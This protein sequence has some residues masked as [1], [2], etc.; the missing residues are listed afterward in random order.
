MSPGEK[1]WRVFYTL[2][3]AEK[4]CEERLVERYVETFLPKRSVWR[5]WTD[6]KKKVIE[7]LFPNYIFAQVNELERLRVLQTDGIVRCVSFNG[8]PAI[9]TEEEIEQIRIVQQEAIELALV[10]YRPE[11]GTTVVVV[12]GPL[13]GLKGEVTE[14]RGQTH[15]V[16][17]VAA[18]RQALSIN[19]PA[20][21][22]KAA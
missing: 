1:Y 9:V 13:Q 18:I 3:R 6:R 11:R 20:D 2:P 22:I 4:K 10:P 19:V 17:R 7:P 8:S 21:W 12:E 5:Q 14:H 16:V 15:I